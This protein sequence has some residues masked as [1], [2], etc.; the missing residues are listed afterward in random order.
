MGPNSLKATV[1]SALAVTGLFLAAGVA[2]AQTVSL[3]ASR[4]TTLMPDGNSV[5]MW[6]WTCTAAASGA[7][8]QA[9]TRKA[10]IGG[11]TWQPPLITV[12]SGSALTITLSN[13]LP[14]ESSLTIVGQLP[15]GGLGSPVRESTARTHT[16]QTSTTWTTVI[17][18]NQPFTP[19]GQ[20]KRAR[21]F[22]PEAGA[23][24]GTQ[25]Y[26]WTALKPGTYLI[27]TGTYPSIQGPMGLYGVLVVTTAPA[28]TTPGTAYPGV[29]YDADVP[30]L[31]SEID[32]L[33]NT[34]A[35]TATWNS[36][37]NLA[38]SGFNETTPYNP[39]CAPAPIGNWTSSSTSAPCYPAAVNY[40]PL[41]YL[42][43]GVSFDPTQI[44]LSQY[45]VAGP[46]STGN[47]LL[48]IVN[49][50]VRMHV[51]SVVGLPMQ[52]YAQDGNVEPDVAVALNHKPAALT[53]K[54]KTQSD[55]FM[56]AGKVYDVIVNPPAAGGTFTPNTYPFFDREL[57]LS[58]NNLRDGGMQGYLFI[59]GGGGAGA[60]GS[61]AVAA[62]AVPDSFL[63]P[64]GATS[65]AGDVLANDIGIH[66]A[67]PAGSCSTSTAPQTFT[68]TG[69]N[70]VTLNPNGSFTFTVPSGFSGSDTFSYCGNGNAS[71]SAQVT[72]A[73]AKVG[74][75]PTANADSYKSTVSSLEIV[76]AP[77]VLVN[78]LDPTGYPL[79]AVL[80]AGSPTGGMTVN[81]KADGSFIAQAP[82]PGTYTFAYNAVN[83]QGTSSAAPATVTLTFPAGNTIAWTVQDTN[84]KAPVT[85]YKWLIEQDL[86]FYINPLCQVPGTPPAGCP[87]QA[88]GIP[89]TLGT[90]FHTSYMPVVAA[91]CTG[92]QSCERGQTV[93]DA[94]VAC[95]SPGVPAGCSATAGQHVPAVCEGGICTPTTPNG[96]LPTSTPGQVNL[97]AN[98]PD[99]TPARYYIS[100]LP[101][102][103]SNPF[104]TGNASDPT[105]A[106]NCVGIPTTPTGQP[107]SNGGCGHSMSGASIMPVCTPPTSAT[108]TLPTAVTVSVEPNP[109]P[110]AM[111]TVYVFEDDN[112]LNGEI[113]AEPGA[114]PGL[115]DFQ[116]ELWDDAGST[117]DA[118]GQM[119][120]DMFNEPLTNALNG[121]I[122]PIS[123]F[124]ACPISNTQ[125]VAVGVIL[126]CP[127]FESDGATI[128]P[129]EGQAVIPNLMPGR[130]GV[131]AHP[132]ASREAR[133]E[134]WIQTNTLDGTH[135]LDSFVRAGEP[136]YFQEYSPAGFHVFMGFANPDVI[137]AHRQGVCTGKFTVE[138]P[139]VP[140][141][142]GPP[143]EQDVDPYVNFTGNPIACKNTVKAQITNLHISRPPDER[144]YDSGVFPEGDPRNRAT[145][146][147]T[148][149]YASLGVLDSPDIAFTSCDENGNLVFTGIP[150]GDYSLTVFDQWL[151]QL[152]FEKEIVVKDTSC[153]GQPSTC[154]GTGSLLDVGTYPVFSWQ[155]HIWNRTYIDTRQLGRPV[156]DST[157]GDLDPA[158]SPGLLQVP[159]RVRFRNGKFSNTLLT[160]SGGHAY[161][162]ETFP[163]FNWYTVETDNTRFRPTG[164]HVVYD[165]GGPLDPS[166]TFA[167]ILNSRG[168]TPSGGATTCSDGSTPPC[169]FS[170]PTALHVP[171]A[172]YCAS[173]DCTDVTT[174]PPVAGGGPGGTTGRI[175]PGSV[176]V[177]GVQ[178]FLGM[179][180]ILDWGKVPYEVGENGGIRGHVVYS[181][182]RPFDDPSLLFQNLWEPLV[183]GVTI[184][185]YQEG[186]APDGTVSLTLVDTTTTSSWD[187]WAQGFRADGVTPN[188]N[189]PGQDPSDPFY[190]YTLKDTRNA[191]FN[192]A[193]PLPSDSQYKCYDGLH[194]F[195]QV[196][197]APYD[198]LYQF[199]S[200]SCANT[201]GATFTAPNGQAIKC[202]TIGNPALKVTP[203]TG[204]APAVLP[205]GKYV[206]E[207]VPP[208]G[209][210]ITKEEDKNILIGD[211]FIAPVTNQF[212]AIVNIFIV[213]DQ[214][215]VN[216]YYNSSYTGPYTA[217]NPYNQPYPFTTNN[218]TNNGNPTSNIGRTS[219]GD[220]GPGGLIVQNAPCV[221]Q[222]RIVP[223]F[224]SIS[225]ESG[226]VAPFAGSLRP[227]CDRKEVTLEDQ[228]QAQTDF[229]VWT[230]TP[231]STHYTGFVLDDFSSEFDPNS[232]DFSEKW[233]LPNVPVSIRDPFGVEVSRVY[234]D[235][236]GIYDGLVYSTFDVN[237]PNPTGYAPNMMITCMNDPGPIAGPNGAMINDP[238]FNPLYSD[239]CYENPF[240]PGDTTY[241]DTPV[242]P[243]S[244][245]AEG[246]DPPDCAYPDATPAVARVDGDGAGPWVSARGHTIT[247]TALGNQSVPNHAYAGPAS[248]TAPYNEK[249]ITRHYGFGASPGAVTIGGVAAPVVG[250]W[251]DTSLTVT[252]PTT[253]PACAIQQTARNHGGGAA[254]SLQYCGELVITTAPSANYPNGQQSIDAVTVTAGG[255]TPTRVTGENSA[256]NALQSAIDAASPGDL[257][258]VEP[259]SYNEM[260]IMWKPLRLQ[261]TGSANVTVN[262][263]AQPAG[264]LTPWRAKVDC[265]FGLNNNGY[266]ISTSNPASPGCSTT[267]TTVPVDPIPDENILNWDASLNGFVAELLQEPTLM[268]AL[269]GAALT[270]VGK[271]YRT[272]TFD[273]TEGT[274]TGPLLTALGTDCSPTRFPGNFLC[275][276]ARIDGMSFTN[277]SA[278]GGGI[279]VHGWNHNLEISNNH[280]YGNGGSVTGGIS[281]GQVEIGPVTTVGAAALPY[282]YNLNVNIH[283][284]AITGNASFGDEFN[285]DTPAAGGG[286]TF[287]TGS[288]FYKFNYNFVC[289]NLT[290][291]DGGGL[292]HYGLSFSGDIEHNQII[293]N[294]SFN[295]TLPT[296]GGGIAVQGE[297]APANCEGPPVDLGC[298]P[299]LSDGSGDVTIN[300][301]LIQGNTAEAGSG[302]G[303]RIQDANG[304]DVTRNPGNL[305]P[306]LLPPRQAWWKITITNN[307]VV[308]NVAGYAGGGI[309]LVDA[310][311]TAVVNNTISRNDA[312]STAGVEFDTVGANQGTIPSNPYG[313]GSCGSAQCSILDSVT[314]S[315][316][317]PAGFLSEPNGPLLVSAFATGFNQANCPF[318][319]PGCTQF[320]NPLLA[321]NLISGNRAFHI[322]VSG[323][324]GTN[325]PGNATLGANGAP[326]NIV[327]LVPTLSQAATGQCPVTDVG[328]VSGAGDVNGPDI[329]DIGIL[330][331]NQPTDATTGIFTGPPAPGTNAG[332][333]KL[334]PIYTL[335]DDPG[336]PGNGN[337]VI[338]AAAPEGLTRPYCNGSRVPPEIVAS[339][340]A[341][342]ANAKGCS[343][344]GQQGGIGVPPGI[345]DID[346]FFP[347]FILTPAATVDEGNNWI[348]MFYGPLSQSNATTYSAPGTIL[349]PLGNY[350]PLNTSAAINA[351]VRGTSGFADAPGTDFFGHARPDPA[352]LNADDIGAVEIG[353]PGGGTL[354]VVPGAL[355][356]G[357]ELVG[358]TSANQIITVTNTN[359]TTTLTVGAVDL[360]GANATQYGLVTGVVGGCGLNQMLTAGQACT[361]TVNFKPTTTGS[362]PA[363]VTITPVGAASAVVTL[364]GTGTGAA[365]SFTA[366]T[367]SLFGVPANRNVKNGTVTVRN[368]A[369]ATASFTFTAAP[370]VQKVAGAA[371]TT[372][373]FTVTGGT[374]TATTVLAAGGSCTV[375]VRYTPL[376]APAAI[377]TATGS[378]QLMGTGTISPVNGPNFFAN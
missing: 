105:V 153:T 181:S 233:A 69:G 258:I 66:N 72:L 372:G 99:G 177:E 89:P 70:S 82:G 254:P 244:A 271:A 78:D 376:A 45:V 259:G 328:G 252:V 292:A 107:V 364:S 330:G 127:H 261:G 126:V 92:P 255:Y 108:C 336:Y 139:L 84:T 217:A 240:M 41:Y 356:F 278:G 9:M 144:L 152:L 169:L 98:N 135:F 172:Y 83:S 1:T 350:V 146:A 365:L 289:G 359:A 210:E 128:S 369:T 132:G 245:F 370:A 134:N 290:S 104:N 273:P 338:G 265:L 49:A 363:S 193:T 197:P 113:D 201:P 63:V 267:P 306:S 12:P 272:R 2:S 270:V 90:N 218:T 120:Y 229:Y 206:V 117:G 204:A 16:P 76:L 154:V 170:L 227:L 151:D 3:T 44:P 318:G 239:F 179:N 287:C 247:I 64:V 100:I 133:G 260:L 279:F 320:S 268:G 232:P 37:A 159:A 236:W 341:S 184:N 221:G 183:P 19:P 308:D 187:S 194:G 56:P 125:G 130:F 73:A 349:Q 123:G 67:A 86:T 17:T 149:C 106:A 129:L 339:I 36:V 31:L 33:Q 300:A 39:N 101:G 375:T 348:N 313:T 142:I 315:T 38:R 340:C 264:K 93:Y 286:V 284:N 14:V 234:T 335:T 103:V 162:N 362:K 7:S 122:D 358:T 34:A 85:D 6:G 220:F 223:D 62:K 57:S 325:P 377:G 345:P 305:P 323:I 52:I 96:Y 192:T 147:H 21:S 310:V 314:T 237:P 347:L 87:V 114:E 333:Y 346:P 48:R 274:F 18:P 303:I 246:Y 20:A 15:G 157:T 202:A 203:H 281:V 22:V 366:P 230:K 207:V 115:G 251:S 215:V 297:P 250:A 212:S 293:F 266:I 160:D 200:S 60:P 28:G 319:N 13:N 211:N 43:N 54:P 257:I 301:N 378:M 80:V 352:N 141:V 262:A 155:T 150:D 55:V 68:T 243:V 208:P 42:I 249:F 213:P 112:E 231:A 121:T 40:T 367:P 253:L 209:Y 299:A 235:Q 136:A 11:T 283:N 304:S 91:G 324:P 361:I 317:Q 137:N 190:N 225:P 298:P 116:I 25:T 46:E 263:N 26:S 354:S 143:G 189:C 8:C 185:L 50:G 81:L 275:A 24:G 171:G 186:T 302:G 119:T 77:G 58:T 242:V 178:G 226:E 30:L 331:D 131:I 65:F 175:D 282:A 205:Q 53:P 165:D 148:T 291:G 109:L 342:N 277:S 332:G 180:E 248:T 329:W 71:L 353:Q 295:T 32:P 360:T 166:G 59:N 167:A 307:I 95:T 351:I 288:D 195:N 357:N 368:G 337:I 110:T 74:A 94:G 191:V 163:L 321:N 145:L 164:V 374:C 158:A 97:P 256:N 326:Q 168:T 27:E 294:Q 196:Q 334:N 311:N 316:Y 4:Q 161:F 216:A 219:T 228:M 182:T 124:D 138:G 309:S 269:E 355:A 29:S 75:K 238:T 51:P 188:M 222:M 327:A 371:A 23:G 5:P 10:Q 88:N 174:P 35:D 343:S 296:Y 214:A 241:L 312:T 199:P 224:M 285:T 118:T 280:V 140:N 344:G 61:V 373:A 102:D 156:L 176:V 198:G 111:L 79:S 47:V 276:P 173:A 322:T